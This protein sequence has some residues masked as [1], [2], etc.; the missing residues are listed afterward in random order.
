M[1]TG[2]KSL[3]GVLVSRTPVRRGVGKNAI[4]AP[5]RLLGP[6]TEAAAPATPSRASERS[7]RDLPEA[8]EYAQKAP[9][10]T[11]YGPG[12]L[13]PRGGR[14]PLLCGYRSIGSQSPNLR[15]PG[16]ASH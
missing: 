14:G 11:H 4:C 3:W 13:G 6:Y 1:R 8:Q 7:S 9:T 15:G 16:P 12:G 5:V 2:R 10:G